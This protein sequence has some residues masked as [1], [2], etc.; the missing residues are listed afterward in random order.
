LVT[1]EDCAAAAAGALL[2]AE[3]KHVVDVS[4]PEAVSADDLAAIIAKISGKPVKAMNIPADALIAGM[5]QA[6]MPAEFG[7]VMAHFDTDAAK[8]LLGV[9]SNDVE[10]LAGR[11]PRSVADFLTAHKAAFAG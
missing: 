10:R 2:S 11:K 8:G 3:G 9:V 4:G 7:G 5:V 1:R 6:G